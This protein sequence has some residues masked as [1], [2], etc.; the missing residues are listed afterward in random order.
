VRRR[1]IQTQA[2]IDEG[3]SLLIAGYTSEEKSKATTGVPLLSDLPLIGRAFRFEEK[4]QASMERFYL[5]TPRLVSTR[6]A[7]PTQAR[8]SNE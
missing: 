4:K 7:A 1:T 8:S 5:L 3:Q 2:L 6:G